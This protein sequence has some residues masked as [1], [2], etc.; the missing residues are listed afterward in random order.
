M[1]CVRLADKRLRCTQTAAHTAPSLHLPPAVRRL[2]AIRKVPG[3]SLDTFWPDRKYQYLRASCHCEGALRPW[4]SVIPPDAR[5]AS[6]HPPTLSL[7]GTATGR[8]L[9]PH[10]P[11]E[12][13]SKG[14]S[15]RKLGFG[16]DDPL[17]PLAVWGV[18][19]PYGR[20]P[21]ALW[22]LSRRRESI[23]PPMHFVCG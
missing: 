4:Q 15:G 1:P 14:E 6:L 19:G 7:V 8:P 22:I 10:R 13:D 17:S 2:V 9:V 20:S 5:W 18:R 12:G 3:G 21:A 11:A 23:M 16:N